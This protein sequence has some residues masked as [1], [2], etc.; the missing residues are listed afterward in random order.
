ME[1]R[2]EEEDARAVIIFFI[3]LRKYVRITMQLTVCLDRCI[4]IY[5]DG[6]Q[7]VSDDS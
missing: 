4:T 5:M 6:D 2:F 1:Y 7:G 3:R